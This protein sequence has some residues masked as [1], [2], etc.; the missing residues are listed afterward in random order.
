[1]NIFC[2]NCENECSEA[3]AACPKCGHGLAVPS[4]GR[5]SPARIGP[6]WTV[7]GGVMGGTVLLGIV[8]VVIWAGAFRDAGTGK[9]L[10]AGVTPVHVGLLTDPLQNA[11]GAEG[12]SYLYFTGFVEA[13]L[14]A[15]GI[16]IADRDSKEGRGKM[17]MARS[18]YFA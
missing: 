14:R 15:G 10:L 8:S 17:R 2:P 11:A 3:A 18:I 9:S 16:P 5:L 4:P 13:Y 6:R 1:M 12:Q 7:K